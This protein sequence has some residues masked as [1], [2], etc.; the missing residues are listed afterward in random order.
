MKG[1]EIWM[2]VGENFTPSYTWKI[3]F[4]GNRGTREIWLKKMMAGELGAGAMISESEAKMLMECS[5]EAFKG[6]MM[7]ITGKRFEKVKK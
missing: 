1:V 5:V 4:C 6:K 7:H 3:G 2:C